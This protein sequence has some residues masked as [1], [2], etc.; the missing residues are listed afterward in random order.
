M[1]SKTVVVDYGIGNVFSV[2]NAIRQAGG[3]AELTGELSRIRDAERLILPG[4]GAFGRAM[5]ALR[6]L[7]LAEALK[8]FIETERPF[9]GICI[10]MQVLMES[11]SEFGAHQGLAIIPGRVER[12]PDRSPEGGRLRVPHIGW[13]RIRSNGPSAERWQGTPLSCPEVEGRS[14]YF[15]HSYH[16]VPE[17]DRHRTAFVEYGGQE[18]TAAV[19]NR[20]VLGV[21]FHPERSG[22]V[23]Q[24]F[25]R[26][27]IDS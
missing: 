3:E 27:F 20:N 6:S 4:V 13:A 22:A 9:L 2:C 7:G 12:I 15:V 17:D 18:I 23:G 8:R 11:S 21:Q 16:C 1:T 25:L 5:D 19:R 26:R 10:G 24:A 14:L